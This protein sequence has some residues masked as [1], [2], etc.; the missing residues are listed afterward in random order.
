MLKEIVESL[1]M[2]KMQ[3]TELMDVLDLGNNPQDYWTETLLWEGDNLFELYMKALDEISDKIGIDETW[4]D[5][6]EEYDEDDDVYYT[7]IETFTLE[8]QES[9]L[10]YSPKHNM[11]ISGWDCWNSGDNGTY[12]PT[13][14]MCYFTFEDGKYKH[15]RSK[16]NTDYD[17]ATMYGNGGYKYLQKKIKDL[18]DI[19]LD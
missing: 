18:V 14:R 13:S 5:E 9:Y 11:F 1:L 10:G 12:S 2:E 17:G 16:Y 3:P 8:G 7:E 19:R 15:I 6:Y 4:E